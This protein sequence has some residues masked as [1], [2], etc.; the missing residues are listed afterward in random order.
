MADPPLSRRQLIAGGLGLVASAATA[1]GVYKALEQFG[2]EDLIPGRATEIA[3]EPRRWRTTD[4]Q[5]SFA[6]LGDN[7]SG[8]RQ[9]MAVAEQLAL[10]YREKP[11]G[12]V[13]LLGDICYYGHISERFDD[14]FVKPMRPLIDAGVQ[15]ELAVGNHDGELFW[16][17]GVPD[18]EA[19]LE[20]LGT[21]GRYYSVERG[22]AE[23]FYLDTGPLGLLG[24]DGGT[25]LEWLDAALDASSRRWKVVCGHHPMY[26]SGAHGPLPG[27][28]E[29]ME[30]ILVRHGVDLYLAGHDHH[31]ERTH[32]IDGVTHIVSG[33]GCKLTP[34]DARPYTAFADSVLEFVRIDIDGDRLTGRAIGVDGGVLDGFDL[35]ARG[36]TA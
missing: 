20:L 16:R 25:Q 5:L 19:T 3:L 33:G 29:S 2:R 11:F 7:G 23:L 24:D 31:Y 13:S 18:V 28:R 1:G 22:P 35:R 30:P 6:A 32:P 15:F 27:L 26:S 17:E 36:D 10:S 8:G 21:T 14:V 9:A 12:L 34:V 4:D